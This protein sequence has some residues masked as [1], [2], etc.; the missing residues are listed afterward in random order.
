MEIAVP[1]GI[2]MHRLLQGYLSTMS[3]ETPSRKTPSSISLAALP[4]GPSDDVAYAFNN[5]ATEDVLPD[6]RHLKPWYTVDERTCGS[7][8][9]H[10]RRLFPR[11][12]WYPLVGMGV[13]DTVLL[14]TTMQ[15]PRSAEGAWHQ[16]VEASRFTVRLLIQSARDP[17]TRGSEAAATTSGPFVECDHVTSAGC[18]LDVSGCRLRIHPRDPLPCALTMLNAI[19]AESN[20]DTY[21]V[22]AP[23]SR[24][25]RLHASARDP[26]TRGSEAAATTS[27]RFVECDHVTSAG[28]SL[29]VS[30]CRLRIHPRDPLPCALTMLNAI[31]AESNGD[32][33]GVAAPSSRIWRLHARFSADRADGSTAIPTGVAF[34]SCFTARVAAVCSDAP[35]HNCSGATAPSSAGG[36]AV[37]SAVLTQS[38]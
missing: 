31:K 13:K 35:R 14:C 11:A 15:V 5:L 28:C 26:S 20:G 22:A 17:S 36:V 6:N 25:W 8:A 12:E 3:E 7:H 24:I 29:D 18:S 19:K 37:P 33:Y 16:T 10:P 9:G 4:D 21:G 23:S 38:E 32:T 27:G 1:S 34:V 30:G 2:E